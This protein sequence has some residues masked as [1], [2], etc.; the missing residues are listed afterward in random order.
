MIR[1]CANTQT[2]WTKRLLVHKERLFTFNVFTNNSSK[3]LPPQ[4]ADPSQPHSVTVPLSVSSHLRV[5]NYTIGRD[6]GEE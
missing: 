6:K 1:T 2:K 3:K 5:P 4:L